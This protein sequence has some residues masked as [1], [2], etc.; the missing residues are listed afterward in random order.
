MKNTYLIFIDH[1][2]VYNYLRIVCTKEKF[3]DTLVKEELIDQDTN[4]ESLSWVIFENG[5]MIKS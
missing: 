4:I 1:K 2:D 3:K 5:E